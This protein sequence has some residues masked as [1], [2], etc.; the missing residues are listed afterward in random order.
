MTRLTPWSRER[1]QAAAPTPADAEGYAPD[2]AP[3]CWVRRPVGG[4][5]DFAIVLWRDPSSGWLLR[6]GPQHKCELVEVSQLNVARNPYEDDDED[7]AKD[8][9]DELLDFYGYLGT[10]PA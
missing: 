4:A 10:E 8:A 5:L 2:A 3:E 9:A 6:L 1:E 7:D